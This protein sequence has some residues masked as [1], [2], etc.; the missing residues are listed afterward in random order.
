MYWLRVDLIVSIHALIWRDRIVLSRV[1]GYRKGTDGQFPDHRRMDVDIP[2]GLGNGQFSQPISIG[3]N[4]DQRIGHVLDQNSTSSRSNITY[5]GR[6]AQ[7]GRAE[8]DIQDVGVEQRIAQRIGNLERDRAGPVL[9][10][11][12]TH[13]DLKSAGELR[14]DPLIVLAEQASVFDVLDNMPR[15]GRLRIGRAIFPEKELD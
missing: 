12:T 4:A 6:S 7:R 15:R 14:F 2:V 10:V 9:I 8:P 5:V 11:D 13:L 3:G 1:P